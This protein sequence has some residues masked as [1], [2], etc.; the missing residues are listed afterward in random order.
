MTK[1]Q[2]ANLTSGRFFWLLL[3]MIAGIVLAA[4]AAHQAAAGTL[5]KRHRIGSGY[6]F[7]VASMLPVAQL[8]G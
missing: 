5:G 1:G 7:R 8:H 4:L 3:M 2:L 6:S